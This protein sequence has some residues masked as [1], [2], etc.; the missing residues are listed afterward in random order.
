MIA[1]GGQH[2]AIQR[3]LDQNGAAGPIPLA[4][5]AQ[6]EHGSRLNSK[7]LTKGEI[8]ALE[9][10]FEKP[11]VPAKLQRFSKLSVRQQPRSDYVSHVVDRGLRGGTIG[12][13]DC[14]FGSACPMVHARI[15]THIV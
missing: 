15:I 12:G 2:G 6:V 9:V 4:Q 11:A 13:G 10:D 14:T 3:M 5:L 1:I 8:L 7:R